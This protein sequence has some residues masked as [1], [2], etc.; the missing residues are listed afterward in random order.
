MVWSGASDSTPTHSCS[1]IIDDSEAVSGPPGAQLVPGRGI[2]LW[3]GL[4]RWNHRAS[5]LVTC[6][7]ELMRFDSGGP[8][9]RG[10]LA[11]CGNISCASVSAVLSTF[12][13]PFAPISSDDFLKRALLLLFSS[14]ASQGRALIG[15]LSDTIG[16][17]SD[18]YRTHIGH[19]HRTHTGHIPDTT[20]HP[21]SQ[22][23]VNDP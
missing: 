21:D 16:H 8:E 22:G 5:G 15:H 13:K 4:R 2:A 14:F 20:G 12:R 19:F 10:T 3:C 17:I 11:L 23:S 18:T 9:V 6:R 7:P 1:H